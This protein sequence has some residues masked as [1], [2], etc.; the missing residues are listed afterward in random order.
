[1]EHL[2]VGVALALLGGIAM[3]GCEREKPPPVQNNLSLV[4][5]TPKPAAPSPVPIPYPNLAKAATTSEN[6][7]KPIN[8]VKTVG[9]AGNR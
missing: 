2:S 7:S 9:D 4:A 1:M 8:G 3:A 6:G 5:P